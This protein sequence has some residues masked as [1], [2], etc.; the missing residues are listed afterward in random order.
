MESFKYLLVI[1]GSE[2]LGEAIVKVFKNNSSNW[3]ICVVGSE[4]NSLADKNILM[5][6]NDK[7]NEDLVKILYSEIDSFT[8]VF[9][10]IINVAGGWMKGSVKNIDVF[11]ESEEMFNRNYY[12]SLLG[13][14]IFY[15]KCSCAFGY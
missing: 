15:L 4:E 5:N 14:I 10:A 8:S 13:K 9:H 12:S 6:K 1:G 7:F 3:R 2:V 11:S